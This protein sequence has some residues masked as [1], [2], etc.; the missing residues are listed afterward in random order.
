MA[1]PMYRQTLSQPAYSQAALSQPGL[2]Q[3]AVHRPLVAAPTHRLAVRP[4]PVAV[5]WFRRALAVGALLLVLWASALLA[6]HLGV[7]LNPDDPAG[8]SRPEPAFVIVGDTALPLN[9]DDRWAGEAG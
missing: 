4:V 6:G 5:Y 1:L 8:L 9:A 7:T 2:P 3:P